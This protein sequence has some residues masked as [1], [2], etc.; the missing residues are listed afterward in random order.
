MARYKALIPGGTGIVGGRLADHLAGLEDWEVVALTRK[1]P[2][3]PRQGVHYVHADLMDRPSCDKA[4]ADVSGVTHLFYCGRYNHDSKGLEP[5]DENAAMLRNVVEAT[6]AGGN[7]LE[8][9]HLVEGTKWYGSNLGPFKTPSK[10][11]DPRVLVNNFYYV[12]EDYLIDRV[13]SASWSYTASRPHGILDYATGMPR[14]MVMVIGVY[15]AISKELGLPL[16]FPGT[17]ENYNALFQCTDATLLAKAVTW[18]ATDPACANE[19]FNMLNGDFFRWSNLWPV[20]AKYFDMELG[21]VRTTNLVLA[22]ADKAP[23]WEQ[24]VAREGLRKT[25]YEDVALWAYGDFL[26]TPHWD[27]MSSMNKTRKYG[28]RETIDTEE[29]FL[30]L[31]RRFQ[32]ARA[33]P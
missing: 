7:P 33:L 9:V 18:M 24:I 1:A 8:H 17:P 22:M 3:L 20:F 29:N 21:P 25:P 10:E 19:P 32:E 28:F 2:E 26:F 11:D 5:I 4:L 16:C 12:Q 15:A 30:D 13:K 23:V 31:F 27:F 14:N 6:E